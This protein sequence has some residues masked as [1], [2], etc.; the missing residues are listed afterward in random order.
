MGHFL[1]KIVFGTEIER[2]ENSAFLLNF[3]PAVILSFKEEPVRLGKVI[4]LACRLSAVYMS[5][6]SR[7][8]FIRILQNG[9]EVNSKNN[10]EFSLE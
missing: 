4:E 6:F 1:R 10:A 8:N 7:E 2:N 9:S 3:V 5:R